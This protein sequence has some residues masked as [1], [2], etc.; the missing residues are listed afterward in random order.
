[1]PLTKLKCRPPATCSLRSPPPDT[2][3]QG[4]ESE[5]KFIHTTYTPL[6]KVKRKIV[7]VGKGI[8]FDSGGYNLK[9]GPESLI[10][11]MKFDMGG[12]ATIFAALR[13]IA[14]LQV[15][16]VE[17]HC[18]SA[19]CEN[20]ISGAAYRPGD[21]ITASNGKTVEVINTD[22]RPRAT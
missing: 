6:G 13:A 7:L 16:H 8:T 1:M 15:P 17:V 21:V 3:G 4:A 10:N 22:G 11:Y 19:A 9:I 5:P 18:I 20:L 2:R 12:A 14:H